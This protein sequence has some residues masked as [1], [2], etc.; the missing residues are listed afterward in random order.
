M[1]AIHT[2]HVATRIWFI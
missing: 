2:I 1:C